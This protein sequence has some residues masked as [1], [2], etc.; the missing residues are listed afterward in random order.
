[1]A[2]L[3]VLMVLFIPGYAV[4]SALLPKIG[5][6]RTLLLSLGLSIS[7]SAVGGLF[8]NLTPWD[9]TPK[10]RVL[11][12]CTIALIGIILAWRQRISSAKSFVVGV[13]SLQKEN[14][15]IF[16]WAG[17]ILL[18]AV[19]I[20]YISSKQVETTFT[21]LWAIP[22]ASAEGKN[23]IQI[24]IRNEEKQSEIYGLYIE[25]DGRRLEEWPTIPIDAN[26]EWITI[27]QLPEKPSRTI[28][29]FLYRSNDMNNAYRWLRL[30][31]EA[32]K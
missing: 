10:T 7:I 20:A 2:P 26:G 27:F 28:R 32:F 15:V 17:A 29:I 13:P 22:T 4:V 18:S 23:Q 25:E 14:I 31:P 16:S 24:G 1:M 5:I 9:L 3:G 12:L 11:W 6:E 8:L 21:Q 19:F 30:S